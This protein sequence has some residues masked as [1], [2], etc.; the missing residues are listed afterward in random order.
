MDEREVLLEI[1]PYAV[2]SHYSAMVFHGLTYDQPKLIT[3]MSGHDWPDIGA[4]PGTDAAE[5][6]GL[7]MPHGPTPPS[8]MGI[9]VQW[10]RALVPSAAG[11]EVHAPHG[12]PLR[13]T[14]LERTLV[15]T[16][17]DPT[18]SGGIMNV[19]RAWAIAS[20][21]FDVDAVVAYTEA[22]DVAVLR[23]RVGYVLEEL[24][25]SHPALDAW[26]ADAGRGGS[27]RLVGSE[28]LASRYSPRWNLSLNAP[29]DVLREEGWQ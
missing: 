7:S 4:P 20:D 28:P 22:A 21:R 15:D 27:N 6:E 19:L 29:V 5:W 10:K 14:A 23:L 18:I 25:F 26:S 24:G 13:Y 16:L 17:Q 3:A 2:L 11:V 8:I 12:V 9:P 1:N